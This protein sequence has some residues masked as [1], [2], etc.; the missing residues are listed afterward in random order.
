MNVYHKH[1]NAQVPSKVDRSAHAVFVF[2]EQ[3]ICVQTG[4][5]T[6]ANMQARLGGKQRYVTN[7]REK[8]VLKN[9][10][11]A[12]KIDVQAAEEYDGNNSDY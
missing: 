3:Y 10:M 2:V 1:K 6:V 4:V 9:M 8:M 11:F 7:L 5:Q 12:S